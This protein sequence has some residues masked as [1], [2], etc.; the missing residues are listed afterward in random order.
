MLVEAEAETEGE[1]EKER[2]AGQRWRG[3][4]CGISGALGW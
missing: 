1:W 4:E 3:K 2:D